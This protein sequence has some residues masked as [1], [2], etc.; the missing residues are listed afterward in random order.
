[1]FLGAQFDSMDLASTHQFSYLVR[2]SWMHEF[3]P[4]RTIASSFLAAP[5]SDFIINGALAPRDAVAVDVGLKYALSKSLS[6]FTNFNGE[7]SPEGNSYA[8]TVGLR[9]A[10]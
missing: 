9:S 4:Y 6:A 10:W 2:L 5:G 3:E 8:G 7:F 1:M